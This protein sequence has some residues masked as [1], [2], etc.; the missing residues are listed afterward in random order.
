LRVLYLFLFGEVFSGEAEGS[1]EILLEPKLGLL[2][3]TLTTFFG[4]IK[5]FLGELWKEV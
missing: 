5:P 3:L 1:F 2:A 4:D